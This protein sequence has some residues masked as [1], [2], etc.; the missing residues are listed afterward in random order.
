MNNDDH[1]RVFISYAREDGR[2]HA[3]QLQAVLEAQGFVAWIDLRDLNPYND[4]GVELERA[5][6]A[7]EYVIVCLTRSILDRDDSFVRR[8][9]TY[10]QNQRKKI[11]SLLLDG[12][13]RERILISIVNFTY[14]EID[15]IEVQAAE[16]VEKL[17]LSSTLLVPPN[18]YREY[19]DR[20]L[21]RVLTALHQ[22]LPNDQLFRLTTSNLAPQKTNSDDPFAVSN[23][24]SRFANFPLAFQ[25]FGGRLLLLGEPGSGKSTTLL[26]FTR[27]A[28]YAW[29]ENANA[30]ISGQRPLPVYAAIH[31]WDG[32]E[33]LYEWLASESGLDLVVL[34]D[35]IEQQRALLLLDGLDE[36]QPGVGKSSI[37]RDDKR[38]AFVERLDDFGQTSM[39]LTCRVKDYADIENIANSLPIVG[40]RV[41]LEP[42]TDSQIR[43]ALEE[44]GQP[45]LWSLLQSSAT[46]LDMAR[47]PL[48]L[49]MLI[50]AVQETGDQAVEHLD[51]SAEKED[52]Y[53]QV[54][55]LYV[56]G[57]YAQEARRFDGDPPVSLSEIHTALGGAAT[58]AVSDYAVGRIDTFDAQYDPLEV[59]DGIEDP[60]DNLIEWWRTAKE[61]SGLI[62]DR[63]GKFFRDDVPLIDEMTAQLP[64]PNKIMETTVGEYLP[65]DIDRSL[66]T[67]YVLNMGLLN[68]SGDGTYEF[69]HLMLRNYFLSSYCY[70]VIANVSASDGDRSGA[71]AVLMVN[72]DTRASEM[73]LSLLGEDSPQ[74]RNVAAIILGSL[75][76]DTALE[77][78]LELYRDGLLDWI[79]T[80]SSLFLAAD[81]RVNGPAVEIFAD[82]DAADEDLIL[83]GIVLTV[84]GDEN[85][86]RELEK[87]AEEKL[88]HFKLMRFFWLSVIYDAIIGKQMAGWMFPEARK[89]FEHF[90]IRV[91]ELLRG[92]RDE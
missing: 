67:E 92:H 42:L 70:D 57:R 9:I 45:T 59:F 22:R 26:A 20:L 78:V 77:K 19:A 84:L 5:I 88:F 50:N 86:K 83:A 14:L 68:L 48:M 81:R 36:L 25:Q 73:A 30:G 65:A 28:L 17:S 10:A 54:L 61:I 38:V 60:G 32:Q 16:I 85:A 33:D 56:H 31:T 40:G 35:L 41:L 89:V 34:R 90:G 55:R 43:G 46:L 27:D 6:A 11:L 29:L 23:V 1:V 15:D 8:E 13:P 37:Q 7:S 58:Q 80:A 69:V 62:R 2:E 87:A 49:A 63:Y 72:G 82:D 53:A 51:L 66:F 79:T 74:L 64:D 3:R 47:R 52:L 91:S 44:I 18:P 76:D 21:E 4:F 75:R 24:P 39:L 12:F 71:L